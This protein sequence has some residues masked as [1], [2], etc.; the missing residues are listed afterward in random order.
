MPYPNPA[1][2]PLTP[3]QAAQWLTT[4][5]FSP[6][7]WDCV[8]AAVLK[9]L[10]GKCKMS[11]AG[12]ALMAVMWETAQ[13]TGQ[14]SDLIARFGA[15]ITQAQ[16]EIDAMLQIAIHQARQ[17]AEAHIPKAVMKG[18]KGR[19]KQAG[20]LAGGAEEQAA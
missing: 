10:D 6:Q 18:F 4:H 16:D 14:Q 5:P 12:G 3:E 9:V 20:L 13:A 11:P 2:S 17:D 1:H 8:V 19:L 15:L 7:E